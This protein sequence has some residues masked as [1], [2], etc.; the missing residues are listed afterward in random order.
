MENSEFK[1]TNSEFK[2][3]IKFYQKIM[4]LNAFLNFISIYIY[5]KYNYI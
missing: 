3:H 1:M 4:I 5:I 2:N